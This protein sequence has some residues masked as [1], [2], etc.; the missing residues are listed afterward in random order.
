MKLRVTISNST[1]WVNCTPQ[2]VRTWRIYAGGGVSALAIYGELV[3]YLISKRLTGH[4]R[5]SVDGP[6]PGVEGYRYPGLNLPVIVKSRDYKY[7]H[8]YATPINS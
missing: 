5:C 1:E 7:K 3:L 4:G 6:C 8:C 2:H